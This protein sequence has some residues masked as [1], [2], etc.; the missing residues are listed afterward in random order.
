M[1]LSI[2]KFLKSIFI[3]LGFNLV[4]YSVLRIFFLFYHWNQ[5]K[6]LST[7]E[8][9]TSL[10]MGIRFDLVIIGIL[11]GLVAL[12]FIFL[13]N[14]IAKF[15]SLIWVVAHALIL[16]VNIVD[17]ELINFVG[18]RFTASLIFMA[19]EEKTATFWQFKP[20]LTFGIILMISYIFANFQI[21][22]RMSADFLKPW[23]LWKKA[24]FTVFA[25]IVILVLTRGG[26]Q[27]KPI[28]FVDAKVFN[29]SFAHELIL[30][31]SF[32][33]LKSF[34]RN[35][36]EKFH[37]MPEEKMLSLLNVEKAQAYKIA[38]KPNQKNV[39]LLILESFSR[40]YI[41]EINTPFFLELAKDGV[42]FKNSYANARR[43]VEGMAA[44]MAGIPSLMDDPYLSSE[45]ST[46]KMVSLGHLLKAQGY[47][48]AFFHG[49]KNGSMRFDAFTHAAGFDHYHGK[50]EYL[51]K[52]SDT[53]NDDGAWGIFDEPFLGYGCS[54]ISLL[55]TPFLTGI[56]T[57][58][59]HIPFRIPEDFQRKIAGAPQENLSPLLK[60][61]YYTDQSLKAFF[62]CAR[63]KPWFNQTIFVF[64]ADH[65]GPAL[66]ENSGFK[67]L[68][69]IPILFYGAGIKDA[70]MNENEY[71]QH[72]DI[73]P[74]V[75]DL[76]DVPMTEQN[77]LARSLVRSGDKTI[78]L[79]SNGHYELVGD[80]NLSQER[81]EAIRQYFSEGLYQ[82]K[83]YLPVTK[84]Q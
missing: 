79:Y 16:T 43:S 83:L 52:T 30:N 29:H 77:H 42:Y 49:A 81:L 76:V 3:F 56:F 74:T 18:R 47:E 27:E 19:G 72:I 10:L 66:N 9:I 57:I 84:T 4:I 15:L 8:L 32:T 59:S 68:Y 55:K 71:A 78:A 35:R 21:L 44:I 39:V 80:S 36:L 25:L 41:S 5:L 37:V 13:P 46:N 31:S 14:K 33:L 11:T 2:K 22:R 24:L 60:S 20:L 34:G 7:A 69:E 38:A 40:E 73:L 50:N 67:S 28:S 17:I 51:S 70:H 48:T 6:S 23:K 54:E 58:S 65:T 63:T 75:M 53:K 26:V 61:I 64:M 45:F 1:G 62:E 82:N 12:L